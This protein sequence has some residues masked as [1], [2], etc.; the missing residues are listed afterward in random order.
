MAVVVAMGTTLAACSN[1]KSEERKYAVPNSLC[2]IAV[3]TEQLSPFLPSG[4]NISTQ[5][6]SPSDGT[7]RCTITVDGEVAV[8]ASRIWWGKGNGVGVIDVA[9]AHAKVEP[10]RVTDDEK[11]F[12]SATGAVGKTEDCADSGHPEQDLFTV[13]QV[14]ASDRDDEAGM[15]SLVSE[16]TRAVEQSD[17]CPHDTSASH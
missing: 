3:D 9:G 10:G 1:S 5:K 7:T 13:I 11:Y 14:F 2:G 4:E 8:I 16:Y 6:T 12:Y 15:K 17:E